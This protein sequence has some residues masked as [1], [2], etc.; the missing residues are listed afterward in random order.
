MDLLAIAQSR[1]QIHELSI[2]VLSLKA[3]LRHN[4]AVLE[5]VEKALQKKQFSQNPEFIATQKT[6]QEAIKENEQTIKSTLELIDQL[7]FSLKPR[8][9][10]QVTQKL[11]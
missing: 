5:R 9:R 3:E 2:L 4:Q 7:R 11:V 8:A 10:I 1:N 6:Y